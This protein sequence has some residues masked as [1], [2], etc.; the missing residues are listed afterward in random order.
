MQFPVIGHHPQHNFLHIARRRI[1][2]HLLQLFIECLF[3]NFA[4]FK[5][6][7]QTAPR[8]QETVDCLLLKLIPLA[9]NHDAVAVAIWGRAGDQLAHHFRRK[10]AHAHEEIAHLLQLD[11]PLRLV[12]DVLILASAAFAKVL[13]FGIHSVGRR[14]DDLQQARAREIAFTL[15]DFYQHQFADN[16]KWHE[17]HKAVH[18]ADPIAA[19]SHVGN[20]NFQPVTDIERNRIFRDLFH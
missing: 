4:A 19:K 5:I 13:A 9:A 10:A 15:G 7:H 17:H 1:F 18:L 11:A 12:I 20:L 2:A 16:H 14:R 6:H 8:A 3:G